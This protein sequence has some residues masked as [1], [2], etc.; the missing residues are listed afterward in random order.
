M[1]ATLKELFANRGQLRPE[2][3]LVGHKEDGNFHTLISALP[4]ED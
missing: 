3:S 2:G 4:E 1:I